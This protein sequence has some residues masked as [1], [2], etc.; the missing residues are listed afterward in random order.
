V[1]QQ[2]ESNR[3]NVKF[4]IRCFV[5]AFDLHLCSH[6]H[7]TTCHIRTHSHA[8]GPFSCR[9]CLVGCVSTWLA[10]LVGTC[11]F[12]PLGGCRPLPPAVSWGAPTPPLIPPLGHDAPPVL[13]DSPFYFWVLLVFYPN[14]VWKC[15]SHG[16][17][18]FPT[19]NHMSQQNQIIGSICTPTLWD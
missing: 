10:A 7:P 3:P 14:L 15:S 17:S 19:T 18:A 4:R 12:G 9:G 5:D 8:Q 16:A 2:L 13:P 11:K 6:S 1:D